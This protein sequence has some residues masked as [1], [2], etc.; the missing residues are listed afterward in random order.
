MKVTLEDGRVLT[1]HYLSGHSVWAQHPSTIHFGLGA[2]AN[3]RTVEFVWPDG[4]LTKLKDPLK[5][6]YQFVEP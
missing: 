6:R 2:N 4:N 5:D 3:I 1:Q